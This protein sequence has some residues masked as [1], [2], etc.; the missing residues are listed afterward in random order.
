M[1]LVAVEPVLATAVT[2]VVLF[3]LR[4]ILYPT[5]VAPNVEAGLAQVNLIL[6][7]LGVAEL[8]ASAAIRDLTALAAVML[9]AFAD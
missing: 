4:S 7:V 2:H 8:Q 1:A 5:T 3:E 6:A 9:A